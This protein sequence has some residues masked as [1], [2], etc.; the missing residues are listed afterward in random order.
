MPGNDPPRPRASLPTRPSAAEHVSSDAMS[1]ALSNMTAL[2]ASMYE[3]VERQHEK[4]DDLRSD[5]AI[6]LRAIREDQDTMSAAIIRLE[7]SSKVE[8]AE[9]RADHSILMA[10]LEMIDRDVKKVDGEVDSTSKHDMSDM[11]KQL[12]VAKSELRERDE[13]ERG[14]RNYWIRYVVGIIVVVAIGVFSFLAGK[15]FK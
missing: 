7:A 13:V 6:Q 5:Q 15:V 1:L 14:D 9:R 3:S 4:I 10:R 2:A 12:E 8:A 11:K